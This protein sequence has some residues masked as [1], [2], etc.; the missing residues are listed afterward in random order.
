M[1]SVTIDL[2]IEPP[3]VR[4]P[5][6]ESVR[7]IL[8]DFGAV[9]RPAERCW[10][11]DR[12]IQVPLRAALRDAGHLLVVR[13]LPSGAKPRKHAYQATDDGQAAHDFGPTGDPFDPFPGDPPNQGDSA[14]DLLGRMFWEAVRKAKA[15]REARAD[16]PDA[17]YRN[18]HEEGQR[19]KRE[20]A[21]Q[22]ERQRIRDE[23]FRSMNNGSRRTYTGSSND[24][25][26]GGKTPPP[27]RPPR[28]GPLTWADTLLAEAGPDL[29]PAVYKA[30]ARVL[31]PDTGGSSKLMQQLN[32]ANDRSKR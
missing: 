26:H 23:F 12:A 15:E 5:Y 29:A 10:T 4:N 18:L 20:R 21:E 1:T 9:W 14:N 17:Y 2:T 6:D 19:I 11:I 31:H 32:L 30:L 25:Q 27:P 28:G 22:A 24:H 7:S 16:D 8:N 3:T 13:K